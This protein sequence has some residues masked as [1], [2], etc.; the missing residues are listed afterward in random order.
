VTLT[1]DTG[2]A[3]NMKPTKKQYKIKRMELVSYRLQV[4]W[5]ILTTTENDKLQV[6]RN[7]VLRKIYGSEKDVVIHKL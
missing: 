7:K 2:P 6:L 1:A 4:K 3:I 5:R